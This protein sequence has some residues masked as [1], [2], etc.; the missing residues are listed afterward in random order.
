[1]MLTINAEMPNMLQLPS[2]VPDNSSTTSGIL[3][4]TRVINR[5]TMTLGHLT[6]QT[7]L[8]LLIGKQEASLLK[9][10]KIGR[11]Q[12]YLEQHQ[13]LAMILQHN[14]LVLMDPLLMLLKKLNYM[15]R[16]MEQMAA[17]TYTL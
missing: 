14:P 10:G 16:E 9:S 13:L 5:V 11:V 4:L 17:Q 7:R 1:M 2:S 8:F 3:Q 12:F 6:K 15:Y